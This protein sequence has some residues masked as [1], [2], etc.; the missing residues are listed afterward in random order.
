MI[1]MR[2]P[3]CCV[4]H[5]EPRADGSARCWGCGPGRVRAE[6]PKP[7][8]TPLDHAAELLGDDDTPTPEPTATTE[9][10]TL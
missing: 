4:C 2:R 9:G 3:L 1:A 7:P 6:R 8:I 5:G 10:Q